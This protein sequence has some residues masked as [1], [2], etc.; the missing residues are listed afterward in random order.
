MA[1][2]V[3]FK[4]TVADYARLEAP[5]TIAI[6]HSEFSGDGKRLFL[7]WNGIGLL[8]NDADAIAFLQAATNVARDLGLSQHQT[9][10]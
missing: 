6:G 2:R 10:D 4:R 5:A 7:Q 1:T 8:F 3:A 9:P